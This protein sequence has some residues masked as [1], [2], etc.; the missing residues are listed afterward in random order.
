MPAGCVHIELETM[1]AQ[2]DAHGARRHVPY[3]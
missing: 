2:L 3:H 1:R